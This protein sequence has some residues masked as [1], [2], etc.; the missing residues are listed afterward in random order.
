M[1]PILAGLSALLMSVAASAQDRQTRPIRVI[2]PFAPGGSADV[3]GRASARHL[4]GVLGKA[5]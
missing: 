5:W 4:Q 2:V 3:F 1:S